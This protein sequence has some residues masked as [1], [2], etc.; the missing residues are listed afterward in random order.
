MRAIVIAAGQ[1]TR[2]RPYT[3]NV[4]KCMVSIN[5]KT[6]LERQI[7]AFRAAG[8]DDIVVIRGY[9]GKAIQYPGVTYVDNVDFKNNNILESLFCAKQ[10]LVGDVI[11]SY[12]DIVYHPN[13]LLGLAKSQNPAALVVDID[14]KKTYEDRTDHPVTEAELCKIVSVQDDYMPSTGHHRIIELGKHVDENDGVAEFIGLSKFSAAAIARL[15]AFYSRAVNKGT[16]QPFHHAKTLRKAYLSDL[17]NH[18]V[19]ED[20]WLYPYYIKG[21]WRE[22]DTVQDYERAQNEVNW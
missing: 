17:L 8:I 19:L 10:Y 21:G 4:P 15:Q 9:L 2:L 1:G 6:L 13:I 18:A 14:W 3:E 12:G 5:G 20:E 11:I 7:E 16:D 22:I